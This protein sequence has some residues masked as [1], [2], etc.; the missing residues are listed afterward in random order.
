MHCNKLRGVMAL[1]TMKNRSVFYHIVASTFYVAV[2]TIKL[3]LS[4][5]KWYQFLQLI[6]VLMSI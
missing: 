3:A 1:V 6:Y 2:S 4:Y 5:E